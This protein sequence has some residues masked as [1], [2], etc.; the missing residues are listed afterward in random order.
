MGHHIGFH[1]DYRK[2]NFC[3]TCRLPYPKY[4]MR[5]PDCGWSLRTRPKNRH[6][7]EKYDIPCDFR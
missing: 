4:V 6:D 3:R 5:C 7:R 1:I 2:I